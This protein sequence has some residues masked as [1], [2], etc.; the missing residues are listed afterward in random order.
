ME[1]LAIE[2]VKPLDAELAAFAAS[3]I[4]GE[5]PLV[6]GQVGLEALDVAMRVKAEIMGRLGA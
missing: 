5:P 6:D 4:S 3:V 2:P 1:S